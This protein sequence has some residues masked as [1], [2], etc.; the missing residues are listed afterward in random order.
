MRPSS[1]AARTSPLR[2]NSSSDFSAAS[3]P[4]ACRATNADRRLPQ[5]LTSASWGAVL[6]TAEAISAGLFVASRGGAGGLQD[7][8]PHK[9]NRKKNIN[10]PITPHL[11]PPPPHYMV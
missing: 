11:C 4:P 9:Q 8:H 5:L 3:I 1:Q 2:A 7:P 10:I 6:P